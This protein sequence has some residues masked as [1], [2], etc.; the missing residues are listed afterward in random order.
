MIKYSEEHQ[1]VK[2]CQNG[3]WEVGITA[4]AADE[5]GELNFVELPKIGLELSAGEPLC[6]VESV[7]AASD[8]FAPVGGIVSEV[9]QALEK[10]PALLNES[11]EENGWLCRLKQVDPAELDTLM[12]RSEYEAYCQQV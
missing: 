5:L 1:W 7:K 4:Y 12:N 8:V 11:P 9:N 3:L 2:V 6:V 10:E